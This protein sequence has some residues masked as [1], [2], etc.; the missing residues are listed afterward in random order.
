[1]YKFTPAPS[2]REQLLKLNKLDSEN[3]VA[4]RYGEFVKHLCEIHHIAHYECYKLFYSW[5]G[6][7]DFLQTVFYSKIKRTEIPVNGYLLPVEMF[8]EER[9]E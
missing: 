1:M 6:R 8:I 3:Y 9:I 7:N 5:D 4:G 2:I